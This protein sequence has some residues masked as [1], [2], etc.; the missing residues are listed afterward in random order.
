LA[1]ARAGFE[2][3]GRSTAARAT[4]IDDSAGGDGGETNQ[5]PKPQTAAKATPPVKIGNKSARRSCPRDEGA[6][7]RYG[8][9]VVMPS[10][11]SRPPYAESAGEMFTPD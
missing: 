7:N 1:T 8:V 10:P 3:G 2:T 4:T 11:S 5:T 9:I 6:S